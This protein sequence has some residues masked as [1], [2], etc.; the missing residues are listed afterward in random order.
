M[1]RKMETWEGLHDAQHRYCLTLGRKHLSL[2]ST[3]S[4]TT[5]EVPEPAQMNRRCKT[6]GKMKA[7]RGNE[8]IPLTQEERLA[9]VFFRGFIFR[10]E[11]L[12]VNAETG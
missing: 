1:M 2:I 12:K 6:F 8:D 3:R 10:K 4:K 5:G 7:L 9:E 11:S